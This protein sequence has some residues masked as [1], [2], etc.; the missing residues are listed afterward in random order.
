MAKDRAIRASEDQRLLRESLDLL[1]PVADELV[2]AFY[3]RL[4]T[5]HPEVWA[6]FPPILGVRR[7]RFLDAIM[8]LVTHYDRPRELL[9]AFAALG[10]RHERYGVTIEHY[11]V[12]GAA[13]VDTMRDLAGAAW[14]ED[15]QGAWI[16]ACTF[17]ASYMMQE[18]VRTEQER[19]ERP[20]AGG[21]P[22]H[23]AVA[24]TALANRTSRTSVRSSAAGRRTRSGLTSSRSSLA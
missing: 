8:V 4:C 12:V 10:R 1:V 15:Y 11:A 3:D 21:Q 17:A 24:A 7:A 6:M 9:P 14:T 13:L 19:R 18:G 23:A 22:R 20:A 2:A 5:D 16:R